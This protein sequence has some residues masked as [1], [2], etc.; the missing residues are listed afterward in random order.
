M[1]TF[2]LVGFLFLVVVGR[3]VPRALLFVVL[4]FGVEI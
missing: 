4:F 3:H 2:S 1:F